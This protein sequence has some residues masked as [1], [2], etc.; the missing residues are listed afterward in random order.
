MRLN[1]N[2]IRYFPE[3]GFPKVKA[4]VKKYIG[5]V[6]GYNVRKFNKNYQEKLKNN[7]KIYNKW[8]RATKKRDN[9]WREQKKTDPKL[10]TYISELSEVC[11]KLGLEASGDNIQL[12]R[13]K[14]DRRKA[15]INTAK[16][17]VPTT[18]GTATGYIIG[19]KKQLEK[20]A[21]SSPL[22]M[23]RRLG[24]RY[25]KFGNAGRSGF[26]GVGIGMPGASGTGITPQSSISLQ[27]ILS[28]NSKPVK[29]QGSLS[30]KQAAKLNGVNTNVTKI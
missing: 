21:S 28:A 1:T 25:S 23:T 27:K 22:Y 4:D 7:E 9:L 3:Y 10:E 17:A 20:Q 8:R 14:G 18:I 16:V 11:R 24:S 5:D 30:S 26:S 13:L 6:S 19:K 12:L 29:I 15:R 2:M